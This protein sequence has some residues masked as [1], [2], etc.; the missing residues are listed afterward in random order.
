M[1]ASPSISLGV[2][3]FRQCGPTGRKGASSS[4]ARALGAF[5]IAFFLAFTPKPCRSESVERNVQESDERFVGRILGA[6]AELAHPLVRSTELVPE[7]VSIIAFVDDGED[8]LIG[9]LFVETSPAKFEH[10]TFP[11][12]EAE[13]GRPELSAVFFAR[14]VKG[15]PRDLGVLCNWSV[16]H[17][18]VAGE[19]Y[20]ALFYRVTKDPTEIRV[21]PVSELKKAFQTDELERNVHGRWVEASKATFKTVAQV[22]KRLTQMGIAQ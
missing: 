1:T 10:V 20:A 4:A 18:D 21:Q 3:H 16:R 5:A 7:K 2:G 17:L 12:C 9:H 13:G 14:T 6:S 8:N 15:K 19:L 22:K 11:S